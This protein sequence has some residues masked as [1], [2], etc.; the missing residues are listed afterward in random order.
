MPDKSTLRPEGRVGL[1]L[2]GLRRRTAH[3]C[4]KAWPQAGEAAGLT[5]AFVQTAGA[6]NAGTQLA[7]P[8][9]PFD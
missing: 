5:A 3:H 9:P 7:S 1:G 2:Q 4:G 6:G 8:P